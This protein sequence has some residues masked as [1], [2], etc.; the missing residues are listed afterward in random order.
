MVLGQHGPAAVLDANLVKALARAHEWLGRIVRGEANG[1]GDVARAQG[2]CRTYV[3]RVVGLAFLEPEITK[4][5]LEGRQPTELTAKRLI[6][7]ALKLPV[8]WSDQK[9]LAWSQ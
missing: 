9:R 2:L 4:A 7:S 6:R 3:T 5:I 1:I 8:L